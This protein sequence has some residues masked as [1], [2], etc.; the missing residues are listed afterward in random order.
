ML[1]FYLQGD[2][3]GLLLTSSLV[4]FGHYAKLLEEKKY[5]TPSH[6]TSE[7][8]KQEDDFWNIK[9]SLMQNIVWGIFHMAYKPSWNVSLFDMIEVLFC[10]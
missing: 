10:H 3:S 9:K 1:Q 5:H 8:H 7:D 6:D 2:L 4:T